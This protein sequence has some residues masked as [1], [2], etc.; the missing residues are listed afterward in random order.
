M[1]KANQKARRIKD[2]EGWHT[3]SERSTVER[4]AIRNI[5]DAARRDKRLEAEARVNHDK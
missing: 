5:T 1:A 3:L 4:Q 2:L